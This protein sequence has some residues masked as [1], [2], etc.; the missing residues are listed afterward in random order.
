M[1]RTKLK[2]K[3]KRISDFP[4][5][6]RDAL[7]HFEAFRRLGFSADDI[8]FGFGEVSGEPDVMHLQL[9]T[10]GQEFTVSIAQIPGATYEQVTKTWEQVAGLL[11]V[12][13]EAEMLACWDG[14]LLGSSLEY[15]AMLA[16]CIQEKGIWVPYLAQA[17]AQGQA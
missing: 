10:Q 4:K 17:A 6:Y 5:S 15:F 11:P 9:K 12:A 16:S 14:H 2:P 13:S 3:S 8:F 7:A 1:S